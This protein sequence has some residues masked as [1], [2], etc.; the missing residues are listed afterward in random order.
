M[1]YSPQVL[2]CLVMSFLS[3]NVVF[4]HTLTLPQA[5]WHSCRQNFRILTLRLSPIDFQVVY[6]W[7]LLREFVLFYVFP[8]LFGTIDSG[9]GTRSN[10]HSVPRRTL[11]RSPYGHRAGEAARKRRKASTFVRE[12]KN[13]M[14]KT[15]RGARPEGSTVNTTC[16]DYTE[17]KL[18]TFSSS[19]FMLM[20][21]FLS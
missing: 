11:H 15:L 19:W 4:N 5:H 10:L 7:I 17:P 13:M 14:I 12:R 8:G 6:L 3:C 20:D 9:L 21:R 16:Y 1:E 18:F 2:F